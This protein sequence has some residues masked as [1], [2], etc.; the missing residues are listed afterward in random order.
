MPNESVYEPHEQ[1]V[2]DEHA[3]LAERLGKLRAFCQE[4]GGTF[5]VLSTVEKQRLTEQEGH[6]AAYLRVLHERIA[7]F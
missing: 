6:M 5:D 2:I 7:A 4:I 1:R 3:A